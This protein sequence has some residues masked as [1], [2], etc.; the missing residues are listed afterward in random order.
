[1]EVFMSSYHFLLDILRCDN[2]ITNLFPFVLFFLKLSLEVYL[3]EVKNTSMVQNLK[4]D[5]IFK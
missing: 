5:A 1:M 2:F 3:E 4:L